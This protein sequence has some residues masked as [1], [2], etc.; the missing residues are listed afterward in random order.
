MGG[1]DVEIHKLLTW[2]LDTREPV[3]SGPYRLSDS[4]KPSVSIRASLD[5]V[6]SIR[7]GLDQGVSIK[8]VLDRAVSIRTS[9]DTVVSIRTFFGH[10]AEY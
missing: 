7:A 5:R 6:V 4:E 8:A 9:L 3:T 1:E 10:S 2:S